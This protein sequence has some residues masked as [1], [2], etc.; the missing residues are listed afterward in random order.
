MQMFDVIVLGLGAMGSAALYQLAKRGAA[1]LGIDQLDPPHPYGSSS[2]ETRITRIACGEGPEY[3]PFAVQSHAIWRE[4]EAELG[5]ELLTQNGLL[6]I[7][8]KGPRAAG[9]D[10]PAF[11]ETTMQAAGLAGVPYRTMTG[12]E[13]KAEFPAFNVQ[14]DDVAYHDGVG[15]FVR[16]EACI[17]AQLSLAR[18]NGAAIH[19]NETVTGFE[20]VRGAVRVTTD[21]AIY[22]A[23]RLII[24]AGPWLPHLLGETRS[25]PFK[26]TRQVLYWFRVRDENAL[27]WFK[28]ERC[29]VFIWQIP[30]PQVVYGFPALGGADDGVKIAT[31]QYAESTTPDTVNR[32][33]DDA[34]IAA[35]FKTY[36]EPYFPGLTGTCVKHHVCLYTWV[37]KARFIID[38]HP[39]CEDAIVASACSGHGFKHSGGVGEL[40]ALMALGEPHQDISRFRFGR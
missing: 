5:V 40:L 2:G 36:V 32:T 37:S 10:N 1:V 9:H 24:T 39:A 38:R 31:E 26:V 18:R 15:G 7:S 20:Q 25:S 33:V 4:I 16:P 14:D 21:K 12:A 19:V 11:L 28:P 17:G 27:S 23:K 30:A 8:G 22:S 35:M 29:P 3:A 6:V 13:V 34:E